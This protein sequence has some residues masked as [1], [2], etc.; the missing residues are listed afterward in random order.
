[1][2]SSREDALYVPQALA[3]LSLI[4]L[5][6]KGLWTNLFRGGS[7]SE[8]T[9][10][11]EKTGVALDGL[12]IFAFRLFR[13]LTIFILLSLEVFVLT[14]GRTAPA[15]IFQPGLYVSLHLFRC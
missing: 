2:A 15:S 9:D 13:L 5:I 4:Y 3:A 11:E 6:G 8:A 10:E 7:K 12:K 1:M 14:V